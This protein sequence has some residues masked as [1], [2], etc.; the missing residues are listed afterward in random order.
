MFE[1]STGINDDSKYVIAV[2]GEVDIYS[3][4]SFK[5][6]LYQS[7]CDVNQD[8]VLDCSGLTYIDSMGLGIMVAALKRARQNDRN[9][10]I[11]NPRTNVKKL[12]KITGL[13]K[14]FIMEELK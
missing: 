9:I 2:K 4:P 1:L 8:I 12:F 3:A 13:D 5:E 11:R 10:R 6:S 14:V 7:I